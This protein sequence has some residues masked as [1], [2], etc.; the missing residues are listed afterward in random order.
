MLELRVMKRN[1]LMAL[2]QITADLN[3]T[4][5]LLERIAIA[6][7]RLAPLQEVPSR[8]FLDVDSLH[9]VSEW[10]GV[11]PDPESRWEDYGPRRNYN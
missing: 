1:L 2:I 10:P 7:E 3:R 6:L 5:A 8:E 4:V 9:N 11:Q